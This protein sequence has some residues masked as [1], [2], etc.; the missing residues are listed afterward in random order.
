MKN[1]TVLIVLTVALNGISYAGMLTNYNDRYLQNNYSRYNNYPQK[2]VAN[3]YSDLGRLENKIFNQSY[4]YNSPLERVE[5]LEYKLF[6]AKQEGSFDERMELLHN[7]ARNYKSYSYNGNYDT[8]TPRSYT[9]PIFTGS[10]GSSWK[11][12]LWGNLRNQLTGTPTGFTPAMD[13]AYMDWFEAER[14]M[15]G[16][17]VDYRS[18]TGYYK[19]K[20]NYGSGSGVTLLD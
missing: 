4:N 3:R 12:M 13:P 11:N 17:N 18:N 20:T 19:S 15:S 5:R 7:A 9:P 2:Y 10:T 14:A 1:L 8:Y 16:R 6:G